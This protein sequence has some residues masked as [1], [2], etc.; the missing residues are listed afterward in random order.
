MKAELHESLLERYA[1]VYEGKM[2]VELVGESVVSDKMPDIGLLCDTASNVLLRSKRTETAAAVMEGE[3]SLEVSYIPD[4]MAGFC[5]QR[6]QLP[7]LMEFPSDEISGNHTAIGSVR[8]VELET[9]MLNPRKILVKAKLEGDMQVFTAQNIMICDAVQA[10]DTVQVRREEVSCS[11]ISTVCEKTFAV[12][13]EYPLPPHLDGGEVIGKTVQFRIDDVKTLTNKLI[14]KGSMLSD[15]IISTQEGETERLSFTSAFS[16][17]ADTD[18][19]SVSDH[20]RTDLMLTAMFYE[21]GNSGRTLS[22]EVHGVCQITAYDKKTFAYLSDTYSNFYPLQW[23]FDE[24]TVYKDVQKGIHREK[25]S[26]AV[27]CRSQLRC[28]RFLTAMHTVSDS[29]IT[30]VVGACV[31][32]ENGGMDWIRKR[33]A[34]PCQTEKDEQV[35]AV[36]LTDLHAACN[37]AELEFRLNIEWDTIKREQ[38]SLMTVRSI[39]YDEE[40][41]MEPREAALTVTQWKGELWDLARKYGSTVPLIQMYNEIEEEVL[42]TGRMLLIPRQRNQ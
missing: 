10:D 3:L 27:V 33:I 29:Q 15:V 17:I 9:R 37:G 30:V 42:E 6:M 13:D 12:T 41:L 7:W 16:F 35:Y 34:F 8:V 38:L 5:V 40:C 24:V 22:V 23:G 36:R 26:E 14:V 31:A 25:I 2:T 4:G 32:Y 11:V 39:T 28:V 18:C 21:V 20:I 19:D 1:M